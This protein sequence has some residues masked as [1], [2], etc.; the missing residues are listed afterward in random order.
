MVLNYIWF[1]MKMVKRVVAFG[2]ENSGVSIWD[3]CIGAVYSSRG[4]WKA[5]YEIRESYSSR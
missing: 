2:D 3:G 1:G 5:N 4:H